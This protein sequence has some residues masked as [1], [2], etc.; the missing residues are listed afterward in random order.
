MQ[1]LIFH[2][3]LGPSLINYPTPAQDVILRSLPWT[4]GLL[5]MSAVIGLGARRRRSARSPAGGAASSGRRSSTNLSIALSHVPF[6]FVAL[7][8]VYVF[9]YSL[10]AA[11]AIGVRLDDQSRVQ[12]ATSSAAC[13]STASCRRCR[14]C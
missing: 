1:N 6:F 2:S 9:A 14:S 11:R 5:G 3:D 4:I 12:S 7:I 10:A 13:S 8:L